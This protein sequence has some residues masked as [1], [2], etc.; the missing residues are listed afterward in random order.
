MAAHA[1]I[2][3]LDCT[4]QSYDWGKLGKDS[5]VAE[6][7][8]A[9]PE[10]AAKENTPYA[11][12]WMGTHPNGPSKVFDTDTPLKKILNATN[13]SDK[14]HQE[15][16][17]DLPFLFKVLSIRKALS[18]QAHPD[19]KLAGDLHARF[20]DIYKDPN[21]KPEMAIALTPFEAFINFRPLKEIKA[22]LTQFPEFRDL[23]GDAVSKQF[24]AQVNKAGESTDAKDVAANKDVLKLL[25]K[26]LME[27]D[28]KALR[29]Q[30]DKLITRIR[31][32]GLNTKGG[33]FELVYRLNEQFPKD[34]GVFCA[35]L[36]NHV[37]L[38]PGESIF[39]AANEPHAYLSGDCVECMAASDNVIRSGLTPKFK[40]VD[41]LVKCLTYNYGPA[42]A[43][44][45]HGDSYKGL[46]NTTL[47][48]PPI[49]EFSILR[50]RLEKEQETVEGI[51]GPSVLIV[52][53]GNGK[54][55]YSNNGTET[56]LDAITGYVFFISAGVAVTLT[57]LGDDP[58]TS[59]R[60][61]C[62]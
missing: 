31:T 20:P 62:T 34:V 21:H 60:A 22:N 42:D 57:G 23:I 40:D 56:V 9:S 3:R 38:S 19:K 5:K 44:I 46:K 33:L 37:K 58:F 1:P 15:Y 45:L 47:Y 54:I 52:T 49:Q 17:G 10:F 36:L 61:F 6:L 4:S 25:F 18:I 51:A 32:D 24:E 14:L 50:T 8:A 53:E 12:L 39:L 16:S 29:E 7:A 2:V 30:L 55:E 13:L 35:F 27:S 41:T 48:D 59:Y 28:E 11:E 43:Q 26:T